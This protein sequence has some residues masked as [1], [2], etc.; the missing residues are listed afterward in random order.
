MTLKIS[1]PIATRRP[2]IKITTN[3]TTN[4]GTK[5]VNPRETPSGTASGILITQLCLT[6]I[7]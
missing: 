5:A 4:P 3:A 1:V 7:R 2:L 6:H